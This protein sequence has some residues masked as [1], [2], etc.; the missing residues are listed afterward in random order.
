[1]LQVSLNSVVP[2]GEQK[3]LIADLGQNCDFVTGRTDRLNLSFVES[4][5]PFSTT[6][7]LSLENLLSLRLCMVKL[8][9]WNMRF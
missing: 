7:I 9:L 5:L 6:H 4:F 1:M 8:G 2:S 3:V